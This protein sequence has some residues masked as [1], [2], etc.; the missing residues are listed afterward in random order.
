MDESLKII[1]DTASNHFSAGDYKKT[2]PI[3]NQLVLK[4][5]KNAKLF[6]MLGAI[7][8]QKNEIKKAIRSF[9]RSLEIDPS[10]TD[11]GIGLSVIYNDLG[12]YEEGKKVFANTQKQLKKPSASQQPIVRDSKAKIFLAKHLELAKL[13]N[14]D[15]NYSEA[16]Q[17]LLK[18]KKF[19]DDGIKIQILISECLLNMKEYQKAIHE[20]NDIISKDP[21]NVPALMRLGQIQTLTGQKNMAQNTF[22][23]VLLIDRHHVGA[24]QR[25]NILRSNTLT[26]S[27]EL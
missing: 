10:F 1:F 13:Y 26:P 15:K 12:H 3:L 2:E 7:Q 22:E 24:N 8:Y 27:K 11:A 17:Q 5:Y 14:D 4:N 23:K 21:K 25:L 9:K 18:A 19:S 16:L 20:L 6:Y